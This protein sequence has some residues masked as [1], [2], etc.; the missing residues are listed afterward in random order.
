MM[1]LTPTEHMDWWWIFRYLAI[2]PPEKRDELLDRAD[3][4]ALVQLQQIADGEVLCA[5]SARIPQLS[6]F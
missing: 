6:L 3:M 4:S 2:C 1:T 5:I